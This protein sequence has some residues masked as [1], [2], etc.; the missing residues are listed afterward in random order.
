MINRI[1]ELRKSRKL[2]QAE[3][4]AELEVTRQ[5]V[6]SLEKG[7]DNASLFLAHR[8]AEFFDLS[9]EDVFI[10]EGGKND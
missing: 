4:A 9:I 8:I 10:F 1:Q 6:L 2:T 5:T 7:K 3:L